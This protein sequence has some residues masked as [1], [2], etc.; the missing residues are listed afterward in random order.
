MSKLALPA[1]TVDIAGLPLRQDLWTKNVSM[2]RSK[3]FLFG[4]Q[5][6]GIEMLYHVQVDMQEKEDK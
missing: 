1:Q 5:P 2:N 6:V 4:Q 3:A